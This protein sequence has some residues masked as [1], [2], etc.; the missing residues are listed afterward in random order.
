MS[1]ESP[2]ED[3]RMS[4]YPEIKDPRMG[5][6]SEQRKAQGLMPWIGD[7]AEDGLTLLFSWTAVWR[8]E[9]EWGA[10]IE[11]IIGEDW[12]TKVGWRVRYMDEYVSEEVGS[13]VLLRFYVQNRLHLSKVGQALGGRNRLHP[14]VVEQYILLHTSLLKLD[15]VLQRIIQKNEVWATDIPREAEVLEALSYWSP[16]Q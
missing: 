2:S 11:P 14:A 10:K 5:L 4:S 7:V 12:K 3:K 13:Q 9:S 1:G 15:V 8:K 16:K 6:Y